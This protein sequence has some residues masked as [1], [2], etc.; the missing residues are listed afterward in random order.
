MVGK[1]ETVWLI[2][3]VEADGEHKA[4]SVLK[5]LTA[6]SALQDYYI[7]ALKPKGYKKVSAGLNDLTIKN[8]MGNKVTYLA[9][10]P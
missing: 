7:A 9:K 4:L 5:S 10:K 2:V 6:Q 1:R 8:L 3:R